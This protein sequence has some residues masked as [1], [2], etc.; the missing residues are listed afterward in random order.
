MVRQLTTSGTYFGDVEFAARR[1]TESDADA[2]AEAH[3][4]SIRAIGPRSIQR[5]SST[6]GVSGIN[7][8]LY[9][10]AMAR[11]EV[12]FVAT[13]TIDG[14]DAVLGFA[15]DYRS[16]ALSTATSAYVRGAVAGHGVGSALL[17]LAEQCGREA[18]RAYDPNRGVTRGRRILPTARYVELSRGDTRLRSGQAIAVVFM[19]KA[20]RGTGR[21]LM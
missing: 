4:D 10:D 21:C 19:E 5:R 12:F 18:R 16:K 13:G 2:M 6:T 20:A 15:S 8:A 1:A 9:I 11:G 14:R 17:R 3:G 7:G